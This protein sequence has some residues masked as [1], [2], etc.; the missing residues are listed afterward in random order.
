MN[1]M[2]PEN[3]FPQPGIPFSTEAQRDV[4]VTM[5]NNG[6]LKV[7]SLDAKGEWTLHSKLCGDEFPHRYRIAIPEP[8]KTTIVAD[9]EMFDKSWVGVVI[10]PYRCAE[11]WAR[12][13]GVKH[14]R[15]KITAEVEEMLP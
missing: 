7:D 13:N 9:D 11:E 4:A 8:R 5:H 1:S 10:N 15:L 2:I 14:L 6:L 3:F 12:K